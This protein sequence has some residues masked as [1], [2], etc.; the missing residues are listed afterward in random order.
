MT[1]FREFVMQYDRECKNIVDT[2]EDF[3]YYVYKDGDEIYNSEPLEE[4]D[5]N[6]GA[7]KIA[8]SYDKKITYKTSIKGYVE[9]EEDEEGYANYEK[10]L[11]SDWTKDYCYKEYIIY[12]KAEGAGLDKFFAPIEK[13]NDKVYVQEFCKNILSDLCDSDE[14]CVSKHFRESRNYYNSYLNKNTDKVVCPMIE[15]LKRVK[16]DTLTKYFTNFRIIYAFLQDYTIDE[17]TNLLAFLEENEINDLHSGNV[18]YYRVDNEWKIKIFDYS[19]YD[20]V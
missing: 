19:G 16:L 3:N 13:I 12:K 5:Y 15:D 7:T 17:L 14:I 18:G 11:Y 2:L 1:N 6:I 8:I 10:P 9:L 4:Y 20:G